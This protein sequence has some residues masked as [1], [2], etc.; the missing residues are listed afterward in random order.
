MCSILNRTKNNGKQNEA[1]SKREI[2]R[3]LYKSRDEYLTQSR[4]VRIYVCICTATLALVL[5][6]T[7]LGKRDTHTSITNSRNLSDDYVRVCVRVCVRETE[8]Q[9]DRLRVSRWHYILACRAARR[10]VCVQ[11]KESEKIRSISAGLS[12]VAGRYYK[13]GLIT[14]HYYNTSL[15]FISSF[16]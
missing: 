7:G 5:F 14:S 10:R 4:V 1:E 9:K 2:E 11:K 12:C 16:L 13:Y 6:F 15:I 3:N 8:R